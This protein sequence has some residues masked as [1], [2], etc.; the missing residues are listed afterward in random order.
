MP[1]HGGPRHCKTTP[2]E[3]T[4]D[5]RGKDKEEGK[6]DGGVALSKEES[7][8]YQVEVLNVTPATIVEVTAAAEHSPGERSAWKGVS[9]GMVF[10][11]L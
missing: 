5:S 1:W 4:V 6:T 7:K 8:R 11:S 3:V 9:I 2:K 10:R